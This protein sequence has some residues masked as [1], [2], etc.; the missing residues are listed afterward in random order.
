VID[1]AYADLVV[2]TNTKRACHL[3][4]KSR[5]THYRR[6]R[7][8]AA[9]PLSARAAP[10][11]KLTAAERASVL[12]TLNHE[13]FVDKSVAQVWA[14]LLDEG[15]YLCSQSTMYRILREAGGVR[16]RRRQATHP[17][18]TRPELVADTPGQVWSWDITKLHGPVKGVSY[19]L[20][21]IIDIYS[22]Y[23]PGWLVAPTETGDLAKAFIDA[24][25]AAAGGAAPRVVH[26]DR[27]TSMTSKPVALL[28]AD[29][30]VVRSHSRP[31]VSNDNPYSEA[32]FKT[33]KYCPAFPDRFGSIADARVFCEQF[34]SYYNHQHR[35]SGIGLHT[36]ASVHFGT[37]AQI[38]ELRAEVL[39][40]AHAR[41]PH[42][43]RRP[44]QPPALPS[45]VWINRPSL[46]PAS[47]QK[48]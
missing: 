10:A 3:L 15:S 41:H 16:E 37:A 29:L 45:A 39:A 22:R 18:R 11:N 31:K 36:P 5:A 21:V 33:L 38:R 8:K 34:F 27:G 48:N 47:Q 6:L 9:A 26:A 4:G 19:D 20:Y 24:A 42:R 1:A 14:T 13:S 32:A 35:H 23:V 40:A 30:G 7:P 12:A 25:I 28:L 46:E 44:P 2:V 17:P 43:F